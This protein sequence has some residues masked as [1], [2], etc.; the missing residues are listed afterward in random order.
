MSCSGS[1]V[2]KGGSFV[3]G[4]R[5]MLPFWERVILNDGGLEGNERV[6]ELR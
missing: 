3:D 1:V 2:R 4:E 5:G 6:I